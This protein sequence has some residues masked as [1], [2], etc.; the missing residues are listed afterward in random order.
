MRIMWG[1]Y[2]SICT[3]PYFPTKCL[4]LS[5]FKLDLMQMAFNQY[6]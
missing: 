1:Y 5:Y 6:L 3:K 4:N 2:Y